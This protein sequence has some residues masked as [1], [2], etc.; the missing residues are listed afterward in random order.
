MEIAQAAAWFA[1]GERLK[2]E[3]MIRD[4]ISA[5]TIRRKLHAGPIEWRVVDVDS[6]ELAARPPDGYGPGTQCLIGEAKT[7]QG[8][9][10]VE[11]KSGFTHELESK[12]LETLRAET[13]KALDAKFPH[14]RDR[15][16]ARVDA[17]INE[18]GPQTALK[19]LGG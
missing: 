5:A 3:T 13:R 4:A 1:P 19:V 16:N 2:A 6:D 17:I 14:D 7:T 10:I 12:D 18:L 15:S 8:Y 9:Y 11:A